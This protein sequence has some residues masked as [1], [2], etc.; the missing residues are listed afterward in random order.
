MRL[1]IVSPQEINECPRAA[2]EVPLAPGQVHIWWTGLRVEGAALCACWDSLP[3]DEARQASNYRFAKDCREFVVRRAVLRQVLGRYSG[4]R[5]AELLFDFRAGGKPV[6]RNVEGLH[7]SM[8]HASD[9]AVLA[10][11]RNPVGIDLEHVQED[12]F[13]QSP[14]GGALFGEALIEQCLSHREQ[15]YVRGLPA[16]QR[17]KALYRCWTRKEAVLK[18]LGT[19]LLYPPQQVNVIAG[20]KRTCVIRL[21]SRD[22][23]IRQVAAPR[24]YAAAMAIE[25]PHCRVACR[26]RKF[27]VNTFFGRRSVRDSA[28]MATIL[29]PQQIA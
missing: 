1:S 21:F 11:A 13:G 17:N 24:G 28:R 9:L 10:V 14:F 23:L 8:S 22:W 19:G 25:E 29:E 18:A 3:A 4:R 6:L 20:T 2:N 26:S 27:P 16:E 15:S 5:A 7:F 12:L